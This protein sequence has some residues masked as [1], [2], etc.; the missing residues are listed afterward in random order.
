MEFSFVLPQQNA[1]LLDG[2]GSAYFVK[3]TYNANEIQSQLRG[4][5][6]FVH[7]H[8]ESQAFLLFF[9]FKLFAPSLSCPN[10]SL[11]SR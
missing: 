6:S 5:C 3:H 4:K 1:D 7:R 2:N 11:F 10:D 9:K 8:G